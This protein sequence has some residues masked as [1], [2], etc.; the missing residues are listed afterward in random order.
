MQL[1]INI[2]KSDIYFV[3]LNKDNKLVFKKKINFYKD[4][5]L[6]IINN[7]VQTILPCSEVEKKITLNIIISHNFFVAQNYQKKQKLKENIAQCLSLKCYFYTFISCLGLAVVYF[8]FPKKKS[9]MLVALPSLEGAFLFKKQIVTESF[10]GKWS[11]D[12]DCNRKQIYLKEYLLTAKDTSKTKYTKL[13]TT[14]VNLYDPE[15]I[16]FFSD[17]KDQKNTLLTNFQISSIHQELTTKIKFS[18]LDAY[19]LAYG[20]ALQDNERKI[21]R[22]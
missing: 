4:Q 22:N 8:E 7:F 16:V 17:N 14:I 19:T 5:Y 10:L 13:I 21:I 15:L 2:Q 3:L 1:G 18:K 9:L 6:Q 20:A 12:I 11:V